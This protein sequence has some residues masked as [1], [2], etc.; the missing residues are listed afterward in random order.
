MAKRPTDE[1]Q[2]DE[3]KGA[4]VKAA[5][6]LLANVLDCHEVADDDTVCFGCLADIED[7]FVI[8]GL[9]REEL[10]TL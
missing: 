4:F 7:F 2:Y 1:I 6:T 10:T 9:K 3:A 8:N 5:L